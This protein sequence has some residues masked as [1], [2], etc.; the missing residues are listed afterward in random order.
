M[1]NKPLPEHCDCQRFDKTA[2]QAV[3][4]NTSP[5]NAR[6]SYGQCWCVCHRTA[7]NLADWRRRKAQQSETQGVTQ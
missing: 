7:R 3:R 2:C 4:H 1:N 6:I 5:V